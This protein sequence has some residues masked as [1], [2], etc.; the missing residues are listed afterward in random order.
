[1]FNDYRRVIVSTEASPDA[2]YKISDISMEYEIVTQPYLARRV[3]IEYQNMVLL[4]DRVLRHILV[5][6]LGTTWNWSFNMSCKSLNVI[7]VLFE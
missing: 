7:L 3:S 5:N 6:K 4:Y 1:M 2:N